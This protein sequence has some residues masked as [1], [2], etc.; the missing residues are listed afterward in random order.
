MRRRTFVRTIGASGPGLWLGLVTPAAARAMEDPPAELAA[1]HPRL[2]IGRDTLAEL[3]SRRAS[4]ARLDG[5]VK[6]IEGEA[7][8]LLAEP[9]VV[10]RKIGRRLLDVSRTALG[11]TLALG[12][13]YQVTHDAAFARRA[14]RELLAAA[15][16]TDWNPSH[17]LDVGEM[18][19]ALA[20]G[21]DWTFDALSAEARA[22]IRQAIVEKGLRPGLDPKAPHNGWQTRNNNWNQVC[23]GGLVLGALAIADEEKDLARQMLALAR[24]GIGHGL[25]P[26]APDGVYPEGPGYWSY[27]TSYQVAMIAALES[28][29]GTDWGLSRSPGFLQSAAAQAQVTGPSGLYFNFSDCRE[30]AGIEPA[31]F[32]FARRAGAPGLLAQQAAFVDRLLERAARGL[33]EGETKRFLPLAAIFWPPG[34]GREKPDLPR[35]WMGRGDNPIAIFRSSWMDADSVY[36]ALKGGSAGLNHAHMDAGSFV[37][38]ASGVR[39]AR[40]LGMQEYESLESKGVDL[41]NRG[42]D[43]ERW[44]VFR[45][46]S[47]S[48]NTLTIDG[49]RHRVDGHARIVAFSDRPADPFAVVDLSSVFAGQ[50]ARVL[51]G[52]RLLGDHSVLVQD[53]L[54]GAEPGASVRWAMVTGAEVAVDGARAHLREQGRTLEARLLSPASARFSVI[55]ADPPAG[56]H[57]AP[58]PGRR[59][60]IVTAPVGA[61]GTLRIAVSLGS[62]GGMPELRPI[63]TW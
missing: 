17:F 30:P 18:T 11:R 50:A 34:V 2:L 57:D 22:T 35:F 43:S 15:A 61:D 56:F 3:A 39:W 28:A 58:N 42:Q 60:L 44:R 29:I 10:Y 21:Y 27:G 51:R 12:F 26:Y 36:L 49:R 48:H 46:N 4:D 8:R 40:D 53:E 41:W 13:A 14:E 7:K 47:D 62:D 54:R 32:W 33:P 31:L 59:I 23:F 37:L 63:E 25:E 24:A 55:P 20:F 6:L 5:L 45:L 19:A 16:F 38:E 52:F 1:G 9:P